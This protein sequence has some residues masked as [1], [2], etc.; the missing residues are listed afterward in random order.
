MKK[1]RIIKRT[2]P[3]EEPVYVIQQRRRVFFWR[4]IDV[5]CACSGN[6]CTDTF[7]TLEEAKDYLHHFHNGGKTIETVVYSGD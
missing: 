5:W 4:W 3:Y 1:L 7:D 2:E 6:N